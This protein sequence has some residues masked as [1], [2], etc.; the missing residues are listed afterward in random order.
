MANKRSGSKRRKRQ[1][2]RRKVRHALN[3]NP[4]FFKGVGNWIQRIR[5]GDGLNASDMRGDR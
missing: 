3:Q 5:Y 2:D 1:L 4:C